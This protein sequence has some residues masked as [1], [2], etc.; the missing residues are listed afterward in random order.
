MGEVA[1]K[2]LKFLEWASS[3]VVEHDPEW[4]S[5]CEILPPNNN[6]MITWQPVAMNPPPKFEG[7][8]LHS[9]L[10]EFYG[11]F[12]G[13]TLE[14]EYSGE[15]VL[16]RVAWNADDFNRITHIINEHVSI[17]MPIFIANTDSDLYFGVDNI[18]GEVLLCEPGYPPI[19]QVSQSLAQFLT[20]I[21]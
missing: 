12:W 2:L 4:S 17:N 8:L 7:I 6:G 3:E 18:T 16:L 5:P 9:S 13:G 1:Q 10:K 11:S 15:S 20:A 21:S 14:T 19:R